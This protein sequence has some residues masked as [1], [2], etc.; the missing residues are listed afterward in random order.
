MRL[1]T[2][3]CVPP[4]LRFAL[5]HRGAAAGVC[6]GV[7]C[8]APDKAGRTSSLCPRGAPPGSISGEEQRRSVWG[9]GL[10]LRR[11]GYQGALVDRRLPKDPLERQ[12]QA[13]GGGAGGR[14]QRVALPLVAAVARLERPL[15][16]Q[17]H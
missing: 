6:G 14:V 4:R 7:G 9:G 11:G 3:R 12:P 17:E 16:H 13:L 2:P 1:T 15:Y 8:A 5:S 10:G